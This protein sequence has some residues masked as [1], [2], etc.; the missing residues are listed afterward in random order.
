MNVDIKLDAIQ[1][2]LEIVREV[3][4]RFELDLSAVY[5]KEIDVR[6]M[7]ITEELTAFLRQS[8]LNVED[9]KKHKELPTMDG[10]IIVN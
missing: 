8:E 3:F 2:D 5:V 4:A 6:L 9:G 7:G 1:A 10:R